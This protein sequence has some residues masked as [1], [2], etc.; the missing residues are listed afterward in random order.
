[1]T[2][3][4]IA[5]QHLQPAMLPTYY[6]KSIDINASCAVGAEPNTEND[7]KSTARQREFEDSKTRMNITLPLRPPRLANPF[8]DPVKVMESHTVSDR[9]KADQMLAET[10]MMRAQANAAKKFQSR[11]PPVNLAQSSRNYSTTTYQKLCERISRTSKKSQEKIFSMLAAEQNFDTMEGTEEPHKEKNVRPRKISSPYPSYSEACPDE[12][13]DRLKG[14]RYCQYRAEVAEFRLR[15]QHPRSTFNLMSTKKKGGKGNWTPGTTK[16]PCKYIE[17]EDDFGPIGKRIEPKKKKKNPG[18][19]K[20][21]DPKGKKKTADKSAPS[22]VL[23][24]RQMSGDEEQGW[25]RMDRDWREETDGRSTA[26]LEREMDG[27]LGK[28]QQP[29]GYEQ[30]IDRHLWG[31]RRKFKVKWD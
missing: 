18:G 16:K 3:K 2:K 20:K 27:W 4:M 14:C 5:N 25:D 9:E 15:I 21:K 12:I 8:P 31:R 10:K 1:M 13:Y 26:S 11:R 22:L 23:L 6:A 17:P 7:L 19:G 29:Q 28:L 30:N 24:P